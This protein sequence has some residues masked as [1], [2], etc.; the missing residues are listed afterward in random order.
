MKSKGLLSGILGLVL[1][2][3]A[4]ALA[5]YN[6]H[7]GKQAG[8]SVE[9]AV[10]ELNEVLAQVQENQE[11]QDSILL[12]DYVLNPDMEMPVEKVRG[13]EYIGV[14]RIPVLE[15]EL[16]IAKDWDYDKLNVT[17]C[18]YTG[19]VYK[20]DMILCA[21]NFP[22]HFGNLRSLREGDVVTFTDMAGNEFPYAVT[23]TEIIQPT[24]VE[25]LM[26]GDWDLTLFTCTVGGK[27]RVT[28]RCVR[29]DPEAHMGLLP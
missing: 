11:T 21:H 28:V 12:P 16:S 13:V 14:L 20:N 6:V 4:L 27:T 9:E 26:G 22:T 24:A 23:M 5:V 19:S 15:L 17:P 1:L 2:I 18:R 10:E 25:D 3:A 29:T 7:E 8:Q